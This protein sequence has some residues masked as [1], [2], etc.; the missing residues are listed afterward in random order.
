ML[1]RV[2]WTPKDDT[3]IIP[4]EPWRKRL[5]VA[6]GQWEAHQE[7]QRKTAKPKSRRINADRRKHLV[8]LIAEI[9]KQ[10]EPTRFS[11]EAPCRHALRSKLCLQ[12]WGWQEADTMAK[13]IVDAALNRVGARRPSWK[14]GQPEWTQDGF[15]P[16]ERTRCVNCGGRLP[17]E[18]LKFC[19]RICTTTFHGRLAARRTAD[20]EHIHELIV[21]RRAL[22]T[23]SDRSL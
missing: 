9:L 20:E 2:P 6:L 12:G 8:N 4:L 16:I 22:W 17:E 1:A 11:H 18:N 10:G 5:R 15:A 3:E 23:K 14:E 7:R 19:S 13:E 21:A